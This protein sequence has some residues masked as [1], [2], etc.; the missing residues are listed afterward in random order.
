MRGLELDAGDGFATSY[1]FTLVVFSS[2]LPSYCLRCRSLGAQ[3]LLA[4]LICSSFVMV[5]SGTLWI[6]RLYLLVRFCRVALYI[7]PGQGPSV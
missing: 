5:F 1:L 2:V 4:V 3:L 7:K 6:C